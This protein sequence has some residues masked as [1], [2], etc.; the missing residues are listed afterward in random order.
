MI[1]IFSSHLSTDLLDT[2]H[3]LINNLYWSCPLPSFL[4]DIQVR[5][6]NSKYDWRIHQLWDKFT[7]ISLQIYIIACA[8][9]GREGEPSVKF[10]S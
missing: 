8:V 2:H 3:P 10:F 9:Y 1:D 5:G 4:Q 6:A 7:N